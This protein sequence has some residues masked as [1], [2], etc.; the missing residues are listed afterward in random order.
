M[1]TQ[2][3]SDLSED[4]AGQ[5]FSDTRCSFNE[6][7]QV[8]SRAVFL[9]CHHKE[10]ISLKLVQHLSSQFSIHSRSMVKPK[11]EIVHWQFHSEWVP[12]GSTDSTSSEI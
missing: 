4:V 12:C 10:L 2:L 11:D 5:R 7:K 8:N 3:T 6:L 9:H 1:T